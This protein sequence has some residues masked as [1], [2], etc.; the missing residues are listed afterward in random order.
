[1]TEEDA[2]TEEEKRDDERDDEREDQ[3]PEPARD[4][5]DDSRNLATDKDEED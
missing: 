4:I 2:M 3:S 5:Y 1:L